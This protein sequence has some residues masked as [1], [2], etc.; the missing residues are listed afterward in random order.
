MGSIK[1]SEYGL[2]QLKRAI[3]QKGWTIS[4]DRWLVEASKILEPS[5]NWHESGP[6]AY[7]CSRQTWERFLRGTVIRDRSFIAF[8]QIL[9]VDPDD[10]TE[11]VNGLR[12]DWGE[13][14]DVPIF[15]GREQELTTLQHWILKEKCRLITIV[16]LAGI[17]K[18]R[19]VRGGIGKTDL[20]LKLAHQV[21]E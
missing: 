13:A 1:A 18:T 10:V 19:L 7:G 12:E 20:S 21:Q 15:H 4:D 8:C 11:S 14:P 9:G 2:T 17:G 16:G 5:G 3:A 6:Y